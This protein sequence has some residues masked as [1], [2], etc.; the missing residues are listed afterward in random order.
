M[1]IKNKTAIAGVG[2]T[3]FYKRGQSDP[4]SLN[5]LVC[6]AIIAAIDDSGLSVRDI[7]GFAYYSGGFDTPYLMETLGIPE[8]IGPAG[9]K[10]VGKKP[11]V[12]APIKRPGTILSQM[13]KHNTPS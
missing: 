8:V 10:I 7:D 11:K 5:E 12:K 4:Q 1:S 9:K 13:P 2:A 3:P 6:K